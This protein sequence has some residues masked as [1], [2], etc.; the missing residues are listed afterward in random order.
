[1]GKLKNKII[2]DG[3]HMPDMTTDEL[4]AED[5]FFRYG[6]DLSAARSVMTILHAFPPP[7]HLYMTHPELHVLWLR[8]YIKDAKFFNKQLDLFEG[9][10][11]G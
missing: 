2:I 3:E 9:K 6:I 11:Y 8:E 7:E 5:I 4:I 1:M 10:H